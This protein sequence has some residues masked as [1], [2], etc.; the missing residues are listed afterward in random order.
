MEWLGEVPKALGSSNKQRISPQQT[1]GIV[2]N[3][4]EYPSDEGL[5][6]IYGGNVTEGRIDHISSRRI[7]FRRQR[8]RNEKTRLK[9]GDLITVCVEPQGHHRSCSAGVCEGGN[10]AHL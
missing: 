2:V 5:P 7:S 6:F 3:P 10:R 1:V 9:A 8:Q 4:S